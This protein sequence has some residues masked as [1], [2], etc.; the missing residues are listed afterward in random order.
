VTVR[1]TD[2]AGNVG[3]AQATFTYAAP[4]SSDTTPP[5]EAITAPGAGATVSGT[6]GVTGT[7]S[8]NTQVAAVA[9]AVDGGAFNAVSGT[10]SWSWKLD[11][12]TLANGAHTLTAR[13]TDGAGNSSTTSVNVSVLNDTAA[14]TVAFS[15]PSAGATVSGTVAVSGSASDNV[16]V[17]KVELSLDGGAYQPA[18]GT[19]SWS[20]SLSTSGL[21]NASHTLTVRATDSSGNSATASETIAVSNQSST[22]AQTLVTPE[23]VTINVA[24]TVTNWTPQQIYDLLKPNAYELSLVGPDLTI[25][26]QTQVVTQT[27]TSVSWT[28]DPAVYSGY[29]ATIWLNAGGSAFSAAPDATIAHEYGAAWTEYH[30]YLT[31]GDDWDP[32]LTERGLFGNPLLDSNTNWSRNELIADDYRMLFGTQAAQSE[33]AYINNQIPDPRTVWGLKNW[34]TT[35]WA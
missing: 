8:D 33:M 25:N 7:A 24:S 5:S 14:P 11:T 19:T 29:R 22:G 17:A 15:A 23:G 32:Y 18:S 34:F 3:T 16:A 13:A 1:A 12:A 28:G 4:T 21:T 26:V 2:S 31:Q 9:V 35:V 10:T 27:T 20:Y 30:L 6:V